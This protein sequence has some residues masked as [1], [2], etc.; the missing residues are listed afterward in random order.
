MR[1]P[2]E[3]KKDLFTAE[4]QQQ[5][6]NAIQLAEQRTSGEIRLF[7]ESKCAFVNA[8]DRAQE[9]FLAS[10]MNETALHNAVL[11]YVAVKDHQTAV[12][13]DEGIHQKVGPE[14]WEAV[15]NKML[16]QFKKEHLAGGICVAI[17]ELGEAL[18]K[19]FPYDGHTDKNELPDEIIFGT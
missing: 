11:I 14:Y 7:I 13:G 17:H 8:L 6:V 9:I 18:H 19:H 1:L 16:L 2:W 5:L 15:V 10:K 12:Y 3:K 4:E